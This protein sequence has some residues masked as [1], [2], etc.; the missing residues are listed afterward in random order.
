MEDDPKT[1][2]LILTVR[3]GGYQFLPETTTE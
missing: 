2:K 3:S 1:P